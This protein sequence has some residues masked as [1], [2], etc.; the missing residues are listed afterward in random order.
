M[1]DV[2]TGDRQKKPFGTFIVLWVTQSISIL[3]DFLTL[4]GLTI[5]LTVV[6]F[7]DASDRASLAFALSAITVGQAVVGL[8]LSTVLGAIVDR[9]DRREFD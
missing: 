1:M 8:A 5:W 6:R 7:P 4:F 9:Y 2:S 3:G